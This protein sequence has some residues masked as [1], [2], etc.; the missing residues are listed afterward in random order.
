MTKGGASKVS[1]PKKVMGAIN[2]NADIRMAAVRIRMVDDMCSYDAQRNDCYP[3]ILI[4]VDS[5]C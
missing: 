2:A 1:L 4:M 5:S 3:C